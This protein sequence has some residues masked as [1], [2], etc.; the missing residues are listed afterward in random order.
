[1]YISVNGLVPLVAVRLQ[2]RKYG[3][4]QCRFNFTHIR[5]ALRLVKE[6]IFFENNE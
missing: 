6:E 1:M 3:Y 4:K 2:A 5:F